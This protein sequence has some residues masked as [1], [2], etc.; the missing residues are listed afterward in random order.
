MQKQLLSF[1]LILL[2]SA[3]SEEEDSLS[4]AKKAYSLV[5]QVYATTRFEE[6]D[7]IGV[8]PVG[9]IN[10][11]PGIPGDIA[12][13]INWPF[14]WNGTSWTPENEDY[15]FTPEEKLDL[16]AYY[17]Y[18]PE[19]GNMP[20]KLNLAEYP[21]DLSGNQSGKILDILWAKTTVDTGS[22][23]V[24]NLEFRHLFSKITIEINT[25]NTIGQSMQV[26]VHNLYTNA[27]VDLVSGRMTHNISKGIINAPFVG[28][29]VSNQTLFEVIVFPQI[30]EANTPLFLIRWEDQLTLYTTDQL[31]ELREGTNYLF[32]LNVI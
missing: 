7:R 11:Q 16:Y 21:V 13:P 1:I 30:I 14:S 19:L 12:Y 5:E 28:N 17:P 8:Y 20:G 15:L 6:G 22:G 10:D 3:C 25:I 2:L 29:Q 24:A 27:R 18:D 32:S 9:Y 23:N 31:I 4:V 26:E